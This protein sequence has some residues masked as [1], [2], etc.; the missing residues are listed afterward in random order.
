MQENVRWGDAIIICIV[1][2]IL[3]IFTFHNNGLEAELTVAQGVAHDQQQVHRL[4]VPPLPQVSTTQLKLIS[5][6]LTF[7]QHQYISSTSVC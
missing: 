3:C 2:I 4:Q 5:T 6:L 7:D 1:I